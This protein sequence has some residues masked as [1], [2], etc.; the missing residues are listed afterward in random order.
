ML[1]VIATILMLTFM[2]Q[3]VP[4]SAIAVEDELPEEF[5]PENVINQ[6]STDGTT[7]ESS[8]AKEIVSEETAKR[9]ENEKHFKLE[10]G[11]FVIAQYPDAVHYEDENGNWIDI[12]NT[13]I[14][15]EAADANDFDGY[16]NKDNDFNVKLAEDGKD[17]LLRIEEDDFSISM[18]L[19]EEDTTQS[20]IAV[21][22]N[23]SVATVT[24]DMSVEEKN[25]QV[26]QLDKLTSK[27]EYSDILPGVDIEYTVQ[28]NGIKEYIVVN[29]RQD[30]YE[31]SFE[32]ELGNLVVR[33]NEDGSISLMAD[34]GEEMYIIPAPYMFDANEQF[35]NAVNYSITSKDD[36]KYILTAT[37]DSEWINNDKTIL[38]VKIDPTITKK[39]TSSTIMDTFAS[40]ANADSKYHRET[41][42]VVGTNTGTYGTTKAFINWDIPISLDE[43][44][45]I[46]SAK[47]M[48]TLISTN[49]INCPV[50]ETREIL[51]S[52]SE[53]SITWNN[54]PIV[55][56][57]ILEY[58]STDSTAL[59]TVVEFDITKPVID[60]F[61]TGNNLGITL[62]VLNEN[63]QGSMA[64]FASSASSNNKPTIE[65]YYR[66]QRGPNPNYS[67]MP[68]EC[69]SYG[70]AYINMYNGDVTYIHDTYTSSSGK[71]K[72]DHVYNSY[73]NDLPTSNHY[74]EYT[75]YNNDIYVGQY[76]KIT[77]E[78]SII[79]ITE[80]EYYGDYTG[81]MTTYSNNID[82][83]YFAYNDSLGNS[84]LLSPNESYLNHYTDSENLGYD[85]IITSTD[86]VASGY[87]LTKYETNSA[88]E[89]KTFKIIETTVNGITRA[90]GY[91]TSSTD[92]S[93]G[94]EVI[95]QYFYDNMN[96]GY[97]GQLDAIKNKSERSSTSLN[98]EEDG[99]LK[100]IGTGSNAINF[101]YNTSASNHKQ[102]Y[103]IDDP[104]KGT[105]YFSYFPN[106]KI[107][108]I[109]AGDGSKLTF[110]YETYNERIS[111]IDWIPTGSTK[112]ITIKF[113]F[114]H[115][116]SS[117]HYDGISDTTDTTSIHNTY[118]LI[119]N[120]YF[121]N[122]GTC[123]SVSTESPKL[124]KGE[125]TNSSGLRGFNIGAINSPNMEPTWYADDEPHIIA[126]E[127]FDFGTNISE[128]YAE[129]GD[130]NTI[131]LSTD[132]HI[133]N[134]S[135]EI[136][137]NSPSASIR[138][139]A[140]LMK[141][142]VLPAGEHIFTAY[143]KCEN[144]IALSEID[145]E[146]NETNVPGTI[147]LK[148]GNSATSVK[149]EEIQTT[150]GWKKLSINFN[151]TIEGTERLY[152]MF[153][154]GTGT[155]LIDDV[156]ID[157]KSIVWPLFVDNCVSSGFEN[158]DITWE[159]T[160]SYPDFK[161]ATNTSYYENNS[162]TVEVNSENVLFGERSLVIDGEI[163]KE[164]SVYY[165]HYVNHGNMPENGFV[166]SGWGKLDNPH[167]DVASDYGFELFAY[168]VYY[169]KTA[170][171]SIEMRTT[172][173]AIPF[174]PYTSDWQY[175]S[176]TLSLPEA[177]DGESI[178]SVYSVTF[179][180]LNKNNTGIAYFDN[181]TLTPATN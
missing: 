21:E 50:I 3:L 64:T 134:F 47:L 129:N 62:K 88:I 91:L 106:G 160:S 130:H 114:N 113:Y 171:N 54:L 177:G 40:S 80:Q 56:D 109:T 105:T 20:I 163:N 11:S 157:G 121:D 89:S 148:N 115:L 70:T 154:N 55:S 87:S 159:R 93:S 143:I 67:Y 153:E 94:E 99:A 78:E 139:N 74:D 48:L 101:T 172:S 125:K 42:I 123:T 32:L 112:A 165:T 57:K 110:K 127:N 41:S 108:T 8:E 162:T 28:S 51:S 122:N 167:Y 135:Y 58:V 166:L 145:D 65:V 150:T 35:S 60:G 178:T 142:I 6:I 76:W 81:D 18:K 43:S 61:N 131:A 144:G 34:D 7:E 14:A 2:I 140:H 9:S 147:F 176:Q 179:G 23:D 45:V 30:E 46:S 71:I 151:T 107:R 141:E 24:D 92:Y 90:K 83:Q 4:F 124:G 100:S 133:G 152:I 52:W 10:D 86:G 164:K 96:I 39:Q 36:G 68:I 44:Y 174:N 126:S 119:V 13:L 155:V 1:K 12:D 22:N 98:Y 181:I 137:I 97:P 73:L 180:M 104:I 69:G 38:P 63:Q 132:A 27:A 5:R 117:V 17:Q 116:S 161:Y 103:S 79:P 170:D 146:G 31:F 111:S 37:A 120:Y 158:N 59:N 77:G 156:T 95:T 136:T 175:V 82:G 26:M 53:S 149:S 84:I 16:T 128:M 118:D 66:D 15:E 173:T 19:D 169:V 49:G 72:V 85:L 75:H 138:R 168:Y 33:E 25:E 29:E 102:L